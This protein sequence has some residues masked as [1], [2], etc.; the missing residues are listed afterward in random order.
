MKSKKYFIT[1]IG[2]DVGKTVVSAVLVEA[3]QAD[4]WKPIQAGDLH[5][6]DSQ[7]VASWITSSQSKF[8]PS[9]YTLHTPASPHHAAAIDKL[10]IKVRDFLLPQTQNSL[11]VE[12]AGGVLVPLN[13][14]ELILDLIKNLNLEVILVIKNYLGSINH[15][16]M[17][18]GVL[19][20]AGVPIKGLIF[21]GETSKAS[22]TYIL[23]YSR[24]PCLG[25]VPLLQ[26]INKE[27]IQ[28]QAQQFKFLAND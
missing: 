1:G 14:N 28:A 26:T 5:N 24:L 16:L 3:L 15:S 21:C 2:T 22:E 11:I 12:G 23:N 25:C 4:Y 18:I 27:S 20:Q 9:T 7:K 6:T 8:F 13:E 19:Q 10:S 17:S